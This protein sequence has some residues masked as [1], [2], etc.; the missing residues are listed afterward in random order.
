MRNQ[1][2]TKEHW[3][4][5]YAGVRNVYSLYLYQQQLVEIL[6]SQLAN[7]NGS[8][9]L[10]VGC[11]KGNE[12]LQLAKDDASCFGLDFSEAALS[13]VRSRLEKEA[14]RLVL[15][16]GDAR[17]LPCK[18]NSFDMI[19]SQGVLEHFTEPEI[20]LLEQHRAVR[21][22]GI[23][24]VEVPNK[25]TLYTIYKHV[26]MR[27]HRW[28]PGWETQYSPSELKTLMN[29]CGFEIVDC[30]GWDSIPFKVYRKLKKFFGMPEKPEHRILRSIRHAIQRNLF[31]LNFFDSLIIVGRKS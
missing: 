4:K 21:S 29:N 22:G 14:A 15:V 25:W 20:L 17:D 19:F 23:V 7:I 2:S 27:L 16:C 9:I 30:V 10:E 3:E 31:L 1:T 26:L 12:L 24:V 8:R 5:I 11:G 18:S 13:L 6:K 28:P